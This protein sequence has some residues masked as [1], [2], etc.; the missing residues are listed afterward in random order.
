M[1]EYLFL[2]DNVMGVFNHLQN[3]F[4][5]QCRSRKK[6]KESKDGGGKSSSEEAGKAAAGH[7]LKE[8]NGPSKLF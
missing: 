2:W 6:E 8:I 3:A 7:D 5:C 4:L 1:W